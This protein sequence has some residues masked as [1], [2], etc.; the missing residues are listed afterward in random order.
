MTLAQ[1][2][3][4][5]ICLFPLL[6]CQAN[7]EVRLKFDEI[8]FRVYRI[9]PSKEK[10]L[11]MWKDANGA[12]YHNLIGVQR[13]LEAQ[14]KTIQF[15]TNA[16][17]YEKSPGINQAYQ[18]EGLHVEEGKALIPLNTD[19][20]K[21]NFYLQPNGVFYIDGKGKAHV[22][23]TKRY[24]R[25]LER[26]RLACQSGPVLVSDGKIHRMLNPA[27]TS[28]RLRN[29]VGVTKDGTIVFAICAS[30]QV[31]NFHTFARL[32]RDQLECPNALFLDGDI[33]KMAVDPGDSAVDPSGVFAAMFVVVKGGQ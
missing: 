9:D 13:A 7:E 1:F 16:G 30:G 12:P 3:T 4:C 20:G 18:P 22:Q 27:G 6:V 24:A 10:L 17:I 26:P 2:V 29:G 21:G 5:A 32:F 15:I 8:T 31:V 23:T 25:N 14:G 28:K 11:L 19:S 33:C